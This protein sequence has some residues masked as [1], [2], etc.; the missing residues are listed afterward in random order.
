[1]NV[2]TRLL[3]LAVLAAVVLGGCS[4]TNLTNLYRD[5]NYPSQPL[6]NVIV[7]AVER[8]E[9]LRRMWEQAIAAEFQARGVLATPSYQVFPTSLPDSQQVRVVIDRDDMNGAVVTHRLAVTQTGNFGGGYDKQTTMS[10]QDYW[11][12][13][14]HSYYQTVML[15]SPPPDKEKKGRYQID[16]WSALDGGRFVW[17]GSTVEIDPTSVDKLREEVAGQLVPEL[18]R[19][20]VIPQN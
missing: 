3:L 14:Y 4:K 8:N 7:V 1:M 16:V 17:T 18:Q 19:Q 5:P 2:P 20:N 10:R 15:G 6:T 12:G 9:D 11:S 13:W